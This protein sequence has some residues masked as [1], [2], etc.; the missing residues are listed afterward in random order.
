MIIDFHTH[1]FPDKIADRALDKLA[2]ASHSTYYLDGRLQTLEQA[3][4]KAGI[5]LSVVLPVATSPAQYKTINETAFEI[6]ERS[7]KTGILSFGGI[8][9]ENDNYKEI[10]TDLANHGVKGIKLHPVYQ[11]TY[12]NDIKYLR[13]LDCASGLGL[14]TVIHAGYDVGY[15]GDDHA[16]PSY[17]RA[18]IDEVH[19]Q[20]FVLAHMGGWEDWD[21]VEEYL[22][23]QDVYMDT[24]FCTTPIRNPFDSSVPEK[25]QMKQEQFLRII[26][27]HGAERFVFGTD[28]PWSMQEESIEVIKNSGLTPEQIQW[29]LCK[30]AQS[31]LKL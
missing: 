16:L 2:H 15:P 9:P 5:D 6:N 7:E 31:L 23:G 3:M 14:I 29:I 19:P 11:N 24:S 17:I 30:T 13:I 8:H 18:A 21:H 4:N 27:N 12:I 10:L 25:D 26:N 22:V 1:T 28:S 20:N